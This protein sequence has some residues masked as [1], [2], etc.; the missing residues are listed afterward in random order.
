MFTAIERDVS[1]ALPNPKPPTAQSVRQ[2]PTT[3]ICRTILDYVKKELSLPVLNH[4]LRVYQYSLAII[5]DQFDWDLSEEAVF[6]TCLLHD[7]AATDGNIASTKMSFEFYG[8]ILSHDLIMKYSNDKDLA[9]AVCEAIIRHQDLGESGMITT[10]GL[11]LQILTILDNVGLH[12]HLIHESTLKEVNTKYS[13]D[14]W[15]GCFSD[16]IKLETQT[17]PWCHTTS[18]ENFS[19]KVLSNKAKY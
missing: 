16:T 13:R 15:L 1:K 12:M 3:P 18:I 4:S 11:I 2:L 6:I 10:L 5:K 9:E 7:L 14:G 19:E 8:G 17:K